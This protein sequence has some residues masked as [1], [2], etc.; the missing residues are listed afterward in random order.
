MNSQASPFSIHSF[1]I[2]NVNISRTGQLNETIT[3]FKET[4]TENSVGMNIE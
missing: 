4:S 1:T 2:S 3:R